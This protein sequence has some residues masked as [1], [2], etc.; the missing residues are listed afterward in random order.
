MCG[1]EGGTNSQTK[2]FGQQYCPAAMLEVMHKQ[3]V[4]A[5]PTELVLVL[6]A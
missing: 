1:I 5:Q 3:L 2:Y 4:D 6:G